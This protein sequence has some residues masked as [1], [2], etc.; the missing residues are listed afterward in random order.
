M[1]LT[2]MTQQTVDGVVQ[3]NGGAS[4]EDRRNGFERGGWALGAGDDE[5]MALITQTYQR[6]DGFLFGRKTYELFAGYWGTIPE[7][8]THPIGAALNTAPKYVASS[9][10]TNPE[11]ADTTVL[12]ADLAAAIG[13]LKTTGSGELQVHGSGTLVR[14][15]L[16][17]NL[18]DEMTLITVPVI[19]GQGTRLFPDTGPDIALQLLETRTDSRGVAI[20]VYRPGGQPRYPH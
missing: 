5:T 16:A 4:D 19:L 20:Q 9:T 13:Q 6:A 11:W 2:T 18:V 12:G 8:R 1:K 10:L 15:L 3:G 7:M 17:N 14:W